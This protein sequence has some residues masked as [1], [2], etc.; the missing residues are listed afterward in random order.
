MGKLGRSEKSDSSSQS[1]GGRSEVAQASGA[2]WMNI[3]ETGVCTRGMFS[4]ST[5]RPLKLPLFRDQNKLQVK[6]DLKE[7]PAVGVS[8]E[9]SDVPFSFSSQSMRSLC[10]QAPGCLLL[11]SS[12]FKHFLKHLSIQGSQLNIILNIYGEGLYHCVHDKTFCTQCMYQELSQWC[13]VIFGEYSQS[14]LWLP[15]VRRGICL[16]FFFFFLVLSESSLHWAESQWRPGT[17]PVGDKQSMFV[18][19][20]S[21]SAFITILS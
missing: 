8:R 9:I 6:Q 17:H 10:C 15:S 2:Y 18:N 1:C 4:A 14:C 11:L 5:Q 12:P 13:L 20:I 21:R 16:L 19:L 7:D 3:L